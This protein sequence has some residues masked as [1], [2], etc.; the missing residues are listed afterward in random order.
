V[1]SPRK[2]TTSSTETSW[3]GSTVH[4]TGTTRI[5]SSTTTT[6]TAP[7]N[8]T[9][10]EAEDTPTQ[11]PG[12]TPNGTPMSTASGSPI[13]A[14]KHLLAQNNP[15][16]KSHRRRQSAFV[17]GEKTFGADVHAG[18]DEK[19]L[20]GYVERGMEQQGLLADIIYG[21]WMQGLRSRWPVV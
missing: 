18:L 5:R 8:K 9:M 13:K 14:H 7:T 11:T 19:K 12:Q 21:Q 17:V 15:H 4:G 2:H 3:S 10:G 1:Q 16:L 6:S 20:P